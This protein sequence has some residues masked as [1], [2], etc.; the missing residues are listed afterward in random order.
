MG[1]ASRKVSVCIIMPMAALPVA[2]EGIAWHNVAEL[3][4]LLESVGHDIVRCCFYKLRIFCRIF[5]CRGKLIFYI[6]DFDS[7]EGCVR[8]W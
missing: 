6:W 4:L 1:G 2:C 8:N 5:F 7:G 3:V